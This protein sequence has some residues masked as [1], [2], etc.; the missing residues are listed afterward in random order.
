M[1]TPNPDQEL[2]AF[3]RKKWDKTAISMCSM[4]SVFQSF[5]SPDVPGLQFQRAR[6]RFLFNQRAD[7]LRRDVIAI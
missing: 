2:K 5:F 4:R 3:A 6:K 7:W 1:K